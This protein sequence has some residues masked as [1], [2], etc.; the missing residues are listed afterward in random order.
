MKIYPTTLDLEKV[1]R[2]SLGAISPR[3]VVL[4][5]TVGANGVFNVAA[6]GTACVVSMQPLLIGFESTTR[7]DGSLKHTIINVEYSKDF[8]VN[9]VNENLAKAA[10]QSSADYPD[11]ISE[12]TEV[13]LTPLNSDIVKA[14]L[15]QE[16][17]ISFE[18]RLSQILKHGKEI[19]SRFVIGE[20]L[21]IHIK[22]DL[23]I[24]G[25]LKLTELKSIGALGGYLFCRTSDTFVME[26]P[27]ILR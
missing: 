14:P 9:T 24:N 21:M 16:A 6:F 3:P 23:Y 18:C 15:V 26:K 7:R 19:V 20:V 8:V 10:N 2:L 25:E 12:F 27:N 22:D 4:I 11:T 13:G 5:S 17:S 1:H